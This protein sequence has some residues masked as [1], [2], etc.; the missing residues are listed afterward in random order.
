MIVTSPVF[1]RHAPVSL[2]TADTDTMV[3]VGAAAIF[4]A[5]PMAKT[6]NV[7]QQIERKER[8]VLLLLDGKRTLKDIGRLI[9]RSDVD[10]ARSLVYLLKRGYAEYKGE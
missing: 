1:T 8:T 6:A 2:K 5:H 7:L 4:I 10:V 9:H 3:R